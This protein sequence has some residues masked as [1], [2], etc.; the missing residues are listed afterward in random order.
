MLAPPGLPYRM[1]PGGAF[2]FV[3]LW[4]E[5]LFSEFGKEEFEFLVSLD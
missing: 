1:V 2:C 3:I 4:K 5:V